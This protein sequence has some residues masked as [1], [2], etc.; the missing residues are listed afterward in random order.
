MDQT[1]RD[2]TLAY[3]GSV[4]GPAASWSESWGATFP[5]P[6][7][8]RET[9]AIVPPTGKVVVFSCLEDKYFY[10]LVGFC[11]SHDVPYGVT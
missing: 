7:N 8:P 9:A 10:S 11:V 2:W 4:L 1:T 6:D 3:F 5:N